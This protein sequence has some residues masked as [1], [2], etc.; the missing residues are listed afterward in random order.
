MSLLTTEPPEP[1]R[2]LS[3]LFAIAH[4][5]ERDAATH[6]TELAA[7]IRSAGVP[8]AAAVFER[9]A[10]EK[11]GHAAEVERW[12]KERAGTPPDPL[13][14]RWKPQGVLGERGA[15]DGASHRLASAYR[16]LSLAVRQEER[17]FVFWSYVVA[18][19]KDAAVRQTAAALAE[20]G[21]HRAWTLRRERRRAFHA[22]RR[23]VREMDEQAVPPGGP[24]RGAV[25]LERELAARLE[26][27]AA[28]SAA[29]GDEDEAGILR[30]MS[31]DSERMAEEAAAAAHALA[32]A[33]GQEL[34]VS[35]DTRGGGRTPSQAALRLAELAVERYLAAAEAAKGEVAMLK[36]Q[37]LA[38]RAIARSALLESL[39]G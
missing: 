39:S 34:S 29:R 20:E 15:E 7:R 19:A 26:E 25:P 18:Q 38:E 35:A 32:A 11:R 21:L 13:M 33:T 14:A 3:E 28:A 12:S 17:A 22:E 16:A 23:A 2:S 24:P 37:S 8:D 1:V 9:L 27:L 10:D 5:M 6:Y 30:R 31:E 36:A 4:G